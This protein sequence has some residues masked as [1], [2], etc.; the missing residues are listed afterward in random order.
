VTAALW[1]PRLE[2]PTPQGAGWLTRAH[3]GFIERLAQVEDGRRSGNAA[4]RCLN[5]SGH[6]GQIAHKLWA[7]RLR[8]GLKPSRTPARQRA[9][10]RGTARP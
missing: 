1:P 4:D 7:P 2:V 5:M 3:H 9:L 8:K 6:R 10:P